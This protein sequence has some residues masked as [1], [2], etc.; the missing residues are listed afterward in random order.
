MSAR[1]LLVASLAALV[2]AGCP[3]RDES[4]GGL[5]ASLEASAS[6]DVGLLDAMLR[7]ASVLDGPARDAVAVDA[8]PDGGPDAC[9]RATTLCGETCADLE[10]DP[11]HCGLCDHPCDALPGSVPFCSSGTCVR[12]LCR[13]GFGNCDGDRSNGCEV[14]LDTTP[15]HCGLC[16]RACPDAPNA[17]AR[18]VLGSCGLECVGG[19]VDCDPSVVGCECEAGGDAGT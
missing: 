16:D 10:A 18:C 11:D 1:A 3:S 19:F 7:D 6:F 14:E 13:P 15:E 9:P 17:R 5:D 2:C 8:P 4:D 12:G